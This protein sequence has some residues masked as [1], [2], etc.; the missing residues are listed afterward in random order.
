M[1]SRNFFTDLR[2]ILTVFKHK[3]LKIRATHEAQ[4]TFRKF[5]YDERPFNRSSLN[6]LSFVIKC[7]TRFRDNRQCLK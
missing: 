4:Y 2:F 1:Q 6:P 5:C 3:Y 7:L